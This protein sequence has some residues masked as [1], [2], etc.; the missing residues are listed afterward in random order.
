MYSRHLRITNCIGLK[1]F[2]LVINLDIV[3]SSNVSNTLVFVF[4]CNVV[5][6]YS[7]QLKEYDGSSCLAHVDCSTFQKV[8]A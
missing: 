1:L 3:S 7:S 2:I 6:L 8:M 4:R 5:S